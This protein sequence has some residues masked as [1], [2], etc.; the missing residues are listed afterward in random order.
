MLSLFV[1][2]LTILAAGSLLWF[3]FSLGISPMPSSAKARRHI[4]ALVGEINAS[5]IADLG[6]GWGSL[7]IP[8]ARRHPEFRVIGYEASWIP[9]LFSLTLKHL[10][11]LDNLTLERRDFLQADLSPYRVLLCYL[12]TTGMERLDSKLAN[13]H[14]EAH[15]VSHTFALPGRIPSTTIQINDL[16]QSPI[17]HYR[18]REKLQSPR[19]I[20]LSFCSSDPDA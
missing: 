18:R 3:T 5:P 9:W 17:Y 8:L 1:V 16:Y 20:S 11:R 13:D 7:V 19:R 15:I 6:S 14:L 4:L 10:L 12:F 2:V